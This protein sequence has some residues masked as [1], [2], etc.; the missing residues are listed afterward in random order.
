MQPEDR[1]RL[2][3]M[4]D[5]AEK[6]VGFVAGR[7]RHD[8]DRDLFWKTAT[9]ELPELLVQLRSVTAADL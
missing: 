4:I 5:A 7:S 3:D 6:V 2:F 8:L 9:E 1:A